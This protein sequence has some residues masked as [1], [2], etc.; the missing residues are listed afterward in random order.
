MSRTASLDKMAVD[1][2]FSSVK[3]GYSTLGT[4]GQTFLHDVLAGLSET[5]KQL[6]PK[7]FYDQR[8]SEL[9][10]QICALEEYYPFQSELELLP[11]VAKELRTV[12]TRDYAMVEFGAGSLQKV[13]PLLDEIA[14]IH[15]FTPI[16]IS[17]EH[18]R[19]AC[20][21]LQK[22]YPDLLV[23]P[24]E[25]DFCQAVELADSPYCPLGFF[26]GSTIG[27]FSPAQARSFLVN[28]GRTLG[29]DSYMLI[30]V[31]TKKAPETLHAAYNDSRGVTASFNRNIL[32]RINRELNGDFDSDSFEHYAFY[33]PAE[34]RVEM[35]LVSSA[36]QQVRI[37][38]RVFR[39]RAGESIHTE[40]S[41]KY[42]PAEFGQLARS[43]GWEMQAQWLS[44]GDLFAT[45]LIR[46]AH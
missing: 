45:Y 15:S 33:N 34:G 20:A 2:G 13:K 35:H 43:A 16:D 10:D 9:F 17:G 37:A 38:G 25:G 6:Q 41:Y 4:T 8:G 18:L 36:D 28:A 7:Y 11:R 42:S 19:Q 26:P 3:I 40:N 1:P 39:F 30:G 12:L 29:R 24:V 46:Y 32:E 21:E 27:N 22:Q 44:A 14:G 23:D 5:P 31:D